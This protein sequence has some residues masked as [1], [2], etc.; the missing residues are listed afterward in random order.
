MGSF[1]HPFE[2]NVKLILNKYTCMVPWL[3][4]IQ[5]NAL[6]LLLMLISSYSKLIFNNQPG[7]KKAKILWTHPSF[8]S[9]CHLTRNRH[10]HVLR[11]LPAVVRAVGAVAG[12][13]PLPEGPRRWQSTGHRAGDVQAKPARMARWK[14]R[15]MVSKYGL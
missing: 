1:C 7:W 4:L 13:L 15:K 8:S 9:L 14:R 12:K 6:V 3:Q 10:L 2:H 11:F 5:S